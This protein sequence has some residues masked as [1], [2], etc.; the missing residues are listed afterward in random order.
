M[1][2]ATK[3]RVFKRRDFVVKGL[4]DKSLSQEQLLLYGYLSI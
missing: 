2:V 1:A 3:R 4:F